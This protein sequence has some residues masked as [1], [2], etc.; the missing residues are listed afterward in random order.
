MPEA[1][2][3]RAERSEFAFWSK[4]RAAMSASADRGFEFAGTSR[5]E[6]VRCLGAGGMGVVYEA[7]D[8]E[9]QA[10][11]ALKTLRSLSAEGLLRFK[12]EF[13]DF[14]DLAH[15]NLIALGELFSE[16]NDW[17]FTMELVE[18][19]DFLEH[20]RPSRTAERDF[21]VDTPTV[22]DVAP[23]PDGPD[24]IDANERTRP[25]SATGRTQSMKLVPS[26]SSM[27]KNQS[28][29]SEK[30]SPSAIRLG[31]ARSRKSRNSRLKRR[32]PSADIERS[33]LSA[34]RDWR[35]LSHAS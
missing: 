8:R 7:F 28:R 16:G 30:S 27:V 5:F 11:V 20:V 14:L 1:D 21:G 24:E 10:K 22:S 26:T 18:G 4:M 25:E 2:S 35:S 15:P 12:K 33:V 32:S 19:V 29:P 31:C 34:T 17:F 6:V 13:R 3:T 9:R 23:L